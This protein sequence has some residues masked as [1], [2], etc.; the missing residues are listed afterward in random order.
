M[1]SKNSFE[2]IEVNPIYPSA[3]T[4]REELEKLRIELLKILQI[5]DG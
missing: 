5:N 2:I 4:A 3:Q 1:E